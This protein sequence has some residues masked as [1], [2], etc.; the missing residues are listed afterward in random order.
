MLRISRVWVGSCAGR[1]LTIVALTAAPAWGQFSGSSTNSDDADCRG[2]KLVAASGVPA[3]DAHSYKFQGVCKL[4]EVS[5]SSNQVFGV[6]TSTDSSTKTVGSVWVVAGAKWSAKTGEFAEK[7]QVQ[8]QYPGEIKMSLKC[9]ADPVITNGACFPVAYSNTTGWDGFDHP[10]MVPRPITRGKTTV[11]E[12]TAFSNKPKNAGSPTPPPP[13]PPAPVVTTPT[14]RRLALGTTM[15]LRAAPVT[16]ALVAGARVALADGRTLVA[17]PVGRTLEWVLV[18]ARNQTLREF[19]PDARAVRE[20]SG[21]VV[22]LV[23]R[24]SVPLGR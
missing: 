17:R 20:P 5:N 18:G 9:A 12:A 22:V 10:Y 4:L 13:P 7:L 6:T 16:I 3:G 21:N 11:A 19:P 24:E 8:G 2:L 1:L 23:G 15:A 14:P